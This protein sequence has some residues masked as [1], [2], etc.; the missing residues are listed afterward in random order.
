MVMYF[1]VGVMYF[2]EHGYFGLITFWITYMLH[3]F[4]F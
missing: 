4:M 3:S 2:E 1:G